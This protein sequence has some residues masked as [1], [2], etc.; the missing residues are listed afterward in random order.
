VLRCV[1]VCCSRIDLRYVCAKHTKCVSVTQCVAVCRVYDRLLFHRQQGS[2]QHVAVCCS[3][4]QCVAMC[5]SVLQYGMTAF[6]VHTRPLFTQKRAPFVENKALV[7]VLQS[8]A[9]CCSLWNCGMAALR[10]LDRALFVGAA[11]ALSTDNKALFTQRNLVRALL[12]LF[13]F[14]LPLLWLFSLTTG[15]F[16]LLPT[17]P[18]THYRALSVT[19]IALF[20]HPNVAR[21]L[22]LLFRFS[23]LLLRLC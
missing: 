12:L 1:A 11:T 4:L 10:V 23:L 20:T 22:L 18:F 13:R 9:V 17:A 16:P 8:A 15:L 19:A 14:A 7:N 5:C 6:M 2:F 21:A 3:V